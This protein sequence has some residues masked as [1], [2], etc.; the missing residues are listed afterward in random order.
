LK[1]EPSAFVNF[2]QEKKVFTLE[3]DDPSWKDAVFK[4]F[5]WVMILLK[6]KTS[7]HTPG[8]IA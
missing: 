7:E 8:Q 2:D 5:D 4:K 6:S 3:S 1:S